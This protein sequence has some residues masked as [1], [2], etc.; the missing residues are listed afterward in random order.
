MEYREIFSKE[1]KQVA[2]LHSE[3]AYFIQ[4]ETKDDYWDF[5][6][7]PIEGISE[8]LKGFINSPERKIFIAKEDEVIVGFIAGEIISCH[9]PISN[10]NKV[11]YIS[12]AF[13]LTEYRGKGIMKKL[14][15]H[16]VEFFKSC[17]INYLE[18]NFISNNLQAKRC[19]NGLGYK[20]F[21][22]QARKRME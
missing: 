8:H 19:W 6:I 17:G 11:G 3:L 20:T 2:K 5:G 9:L 22:E 13:V 7:L 12:G 16:I 10:T 14:E 4:Q 15:M 18:V 1:I 21:R